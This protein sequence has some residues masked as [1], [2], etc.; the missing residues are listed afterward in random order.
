ME[1]EAAKIE[2]AN[3][4]ERD[5]IEERMGDT[6]NENNAGYEAFPSDILSDPGHVIRKQ[7]RFIT[8]IDDGGYHVADP[9]SVEGQL[10]MDNGEI[11]TEAVSRNIAVERMNEPRV[12]AFERKLK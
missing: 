10:G 6:F 5:T 12:R 9:F 8:K 7:T 1:D 4:K 3:Q 11:H 2:A